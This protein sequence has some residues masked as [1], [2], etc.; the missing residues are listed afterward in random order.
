MLTFEDARATA[1]SELRA[2][3]VVYLAHRLVD[4][5]TDDFASEEDQTYL[6]RFA[7][8]VELTRWQAHAGLLKGAA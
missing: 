6:Q 2:V 7:S 5:E 8:S 3:D 1:T 4:P